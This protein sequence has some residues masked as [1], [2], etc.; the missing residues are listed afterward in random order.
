MN[1]V[2]IG[3]GNVATHL[4]EALKNAGESIVQ[5]FSRTEASAKALA[6]RL[7]TA[8]TTDL[9]SILRNADIYIYAL[10]DN[11][12]KDI[13]EKI[14]NTHGIH[15]HTA[16]SV[17]MNIFSNHCQHFGVLYPLQTFTKTK[18]VDFSEVPLFI[19][20]SDEQTETTLHD[21]AQKISNKIYLTTSAEREKLHLAAVFACNFVNHMFTI[22]D[23]LLG[24]IPFSAL[25]PLINETVKKAQTMPPAQAQTGPAQRGDTVTMTKHLQLLASNT[26]W[27]TI[28]Q[29]ISDDIVRQHANNEKQ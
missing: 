2:V 11:A 22:A 21:L 10:T 4:A 16:G 25:T 19:E 8:Y 3:A 27:Q 14:S 17:P 23:D 13:I 6:N 5:V 26:D 29:K 24:K 9:N 18:K 15:L 7:Q 20:A 12:L 28:Y 1:I